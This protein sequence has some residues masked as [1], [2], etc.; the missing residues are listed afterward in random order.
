MDPGFV[1]GV[2]EKVRIVTGNP[3]K[4]SHGAMP[5]GEP[6]NYSLFLAA[7][8][9]RGAGTVLTISLRSHTLA[10]ATFDPEGL[11]GVARGDADAS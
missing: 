7:P 10:S 6:R 1:V 9:V 2:G 3:G 5:E 11:D 8:V 4:K